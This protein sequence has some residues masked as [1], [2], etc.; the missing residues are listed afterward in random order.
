VVHAVCRSRKQCKNSTQQPRGYRIFAANIVIAKSRFCD[1]VLQRV[2]TYSYFPQFIIA[3]YSHAYTAELH[4]RRWENGEQSRL[5][6]RLL[7]LHVAVS[8]TDAA[9]LLAFAS[10]GESDKFDEWSPN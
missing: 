5:G 8:E 7:R 9:A 10:V 3:K 2:Y 4:G 1:S 6:R